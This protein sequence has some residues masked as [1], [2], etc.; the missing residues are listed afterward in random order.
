MYNIIFSPNYP[1][2]IKGTLFVYKIQKLVFFK[3][4][5]RRKYIPYVKKSYGFKKN[6]YVFFTSSILKKVI[7]FDII[8]FVFKRLG[9]NSR[10]FRSNNMF[11]FLSA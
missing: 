8:S 4:T 2:S 5:D 10:G 6:T 11:A 1:P 9:K 7:T 3:S